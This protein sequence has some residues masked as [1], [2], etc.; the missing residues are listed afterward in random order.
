[1]IR[2]RGSHPY[3][4]HMRHLLV[5]ASV[6]VLFGIAN[7][8]G[9]CLD[10]T[11]FIASGGL[12]LWGIAVGQLNDDTLLD[13]AVSN[14]LTSDV[15]LFFGNGDGTFQ[16]ALTLDVDTFPTDIVAADL[17]GDDRADL[18][19]AHAGQVD[20]LLNL[21]GGSF[22]APVV[23]PIPLGETWTL[24]ARDLDGDTFV[25]L[26]VPH[27]A[28]G[29]GLAV[30][31][32]NGDGTFQ[33]AVNHPTDVTAT[34]LDLADLNEDGHLDVLYTHLAG[35]GEVDHFWSVLWGTGPGTFGTR[36]HV[37]HPHTSIFA[38]TFDLNGDGHA[39]V[40]VSDSYPDP[41][42][43][44]MGD[45]SGSFAV[46]IAMQAGAGPSFVRF[47]DMDLDGHKDLLVADYYG[48]A[49]HVLPGDG[50]GQ[51]GAAVSCSATVDPIDFA[52]GDFNG[53]ALP[54]IVIPA[55]IGAYVGVILNCVV[56]GVPEYDGA[57]LR[58]WPNPTTDAV[59]VAGLHPGDAVEVF[60]STG[61]RAAVRAVG[62][63]A[64]V[65]LT[66]LAAGVYALRATVH[67]VV[68]H[69]RVVVR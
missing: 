15:S 57:G 12:D 40:V 27:G 17:N 49:M 63:G 42:A 65:S 35:F 7:A 32:G 53:D 68:L 33:P 36:T 30:L 66:G 8:Q 67:G 4:V 59:T 11:G 60:T 9:P 44:C 56:A 29:G 47:V 10:Y 51:F 37:P 23:V 58:V 45:G 26:L 64:T 39:D 21:S 62:E 28:G 61:Q 6:F 34:S 50:A 38:S 48:N 3:L 16:P 5:G 43:L 22:A 69:A 19:T 31:L 1:M 54:D 20:I 2:V 14:H 25:D 41:L 13:M 46:P 24:L 52:V 55:S 18:V